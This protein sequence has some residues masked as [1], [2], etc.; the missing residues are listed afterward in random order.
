MQANKFTDIKAI[1]KKT[2]KLRIHGILYDRM[3]SCIL[4]NKLNAIP[5]PV[6]MSAKDNAKMKLKVKL[7]FLENW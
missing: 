3:C 4:V 1:V 5:M 6:A 7:F 2:S